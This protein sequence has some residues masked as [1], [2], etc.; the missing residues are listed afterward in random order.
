MAVWKLGQEPHCPEFGMVVERLNADT[1]IEGEFGH[2][3]LPLSRARAASQ[4]SL[5]HEAKLADALRW[6]EEGLKAHAHAEEWRPRHEKGRGTS[7]Q[8]LMACL[9]A[10]SSARTFF[11]SCVYPTEVLL[12]VGV[13]ALSLGVGAGGVSATEAEDSENSAGVRWGVGLNAARRR[14]GLEEGVGPTYARSSSTRSSVRCHSDQSECQISDSEPAGPYGWRH[15]RSLGKATRDRLKPSNAVDGHTGTVLDGCCPSRLGGRAESK[16]H[17]YGTRTTDPSGRV[18]TGT[19]ICRAISWGHCNL[20]KLRWLE[21]RD[22]G[23]GG[24]A[25]AHVTREQD[26]G[27]DLEPPPHSVLPPSR[28]PKPALHQHTRAPAETEVTVPLKQSQDEGA[29]SAPGQRMRTSEGKVHPKP[30]TGDLQTSP[31]RTRG[32]QLLGHQIVL[33]RS[34]KAALFRRGGLISTKVRAWTMSR[35]PDRAPLSKS[36]TSI[37]GSNPHGM[38]NLWLPGAP[39]EE[40]DEG[41]R[42]DFDVPEDPRGLERALDHARSRPG[43]GPTGPRKGMRPSHGHRAR[44]QHTPKTSRESHPGR[45]KTN[46]EGAL[47]PTKRTCQDEKTSVRE[48]GVN[49]D[50]TYAPETKPGPPQ[51][52]TATANRLRIEA[53]AGVEGASPRAAVQVV[54]ERARSLTDRKQPQDIVGDS[55]APHPS[56]EATKASKKSPQVTPAQRK[57]AAVLNSL[58]QLKK[59]RAYIPNMRNSHATIIARDVENFE[60]RKIGEGVLRHWADGAFVP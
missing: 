54:V 8:H 10:S 57:M 5:K 44:S 45:V 3:S 49:H 17:G 41:G 26:S 12:R 39:A 19:T 30:R 35:G 55:A 13:G 29:H 14:R 11:V 40:A 51:A 7:S 42:A 34:P 46:S 33:I 52:I 48:G 24:H 28:T 25:Q 53:K 18:T 15:R 47:R 43:A 56:Q 58:P 2:W 20:E 4:F 21:I 32:A 1:T 27:A 59:E 60:S 22:K 6:F 16:R 36:M 23:L 50:N 37:S 9:T 31:A 38:P